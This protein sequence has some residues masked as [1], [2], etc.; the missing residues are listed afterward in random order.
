VSVCVQADKGRI[1]PTI[2]SLERQSIEVSEGL[3]VRVSV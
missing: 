3:S 2:L 1:M